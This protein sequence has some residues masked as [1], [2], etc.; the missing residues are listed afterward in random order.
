[1][2]EERRIKKEVVFAMAMAAILNV[3]LNEMAAAQAAFI[4]DVIKEKTL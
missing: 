4:D 1:M 2:S 3:S